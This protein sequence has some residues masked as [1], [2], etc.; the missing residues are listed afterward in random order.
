MINIM[1]SNLSIS[2][3][4]MQKMYPDILSIL[5]KFEICHQEQKLSIFLKRPKIAL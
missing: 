4:I 1:K 2:F 5:P 3:K